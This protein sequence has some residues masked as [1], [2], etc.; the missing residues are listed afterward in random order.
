MRGMHTPQARFEGRSGCAFAPH[1]AGGGK[2]VSA[3]PARLLNGSGDR[4]MR[5]GSVLIP[6][7]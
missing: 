7:R 6:C 4:P 1:S 2:P 3:R 5:A